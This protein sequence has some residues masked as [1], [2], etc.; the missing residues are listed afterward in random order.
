[1]PSEPSD[2]R[3]TLLLQRMSDGDE[4]AAEELLPLLYG[5]LR[6]IA[7]RH[8]RN[9]REAGTLQ[10]TALVHE[11]WLRI[12]ADTDRAWEGRSHFLRV[13]ARAMRNVLV[14]HARAKRAGKRGGANARVVL[15]EALAAFEADQLDLLAL[16]EAMGRLSGRDEE[17]S[18][19]VELHIFAGLTLEE[20]GTVLGKTERQIGRSWELARG[21]L[22]REMV[23]GISD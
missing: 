10:T 6:D 1:M 21:F 11:A 5:E 17:L 4:S 16:D 15:D 18:R 9:E 7:R 3:T 13:A 19:I 12:G 8:M 22:H 2:L 20:T 14:D 23:R